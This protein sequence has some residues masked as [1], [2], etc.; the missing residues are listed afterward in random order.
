[1]VVEEF[2]ENKIKKIVRI[3]KE[4]GYGELNKEFWL[5]SPAILSSLILDIYNSKDKEPE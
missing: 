2:W 1:M 5:R 4:Y 3:C